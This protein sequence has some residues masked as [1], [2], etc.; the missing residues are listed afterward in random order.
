MLSRLMKRPENAQVAVQEDRPAPV[1]P[2]VDI[3]ETPEEVILVADLP[4]VSQEGV[5]VTVEQGV[6]TIR[7]RSSV[8]SPERLKPVW[9]EYQPADYER[10]FTL[11]QSI[12]QSAI[13][14]TVRDG[15][16]RLQLPK[17]KEARPHRIEIR[18]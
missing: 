12:D 5:E 6:L 16:L 15:T 14:A 17:A 8:R 4:G 11:S 13:N 10:S 9:Q 2:A 7:G 3:R 1:V 18:S